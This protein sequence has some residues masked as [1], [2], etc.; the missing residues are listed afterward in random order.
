M[1]KKCAIVGTAESYSMTPW[2]DT[3]IKIVALNDSYVLG[4]PRIDEF[5]ELHPLDKMYFRPRDQRRVLETAV[6]PGHYV[7][8]EGH[9][10]FLKEAAKTIPVWLQH[11]PPTD[12]PEKAC[13]FPIEAI[14]AKYGTYWASGPAYELMHLYER[15][16]REIHIYG[17]HLATD[18]ERQDQRHNFEFLI[19]RLLGPEM[20]ESRQGDLR[21]FEGRETKIVLP[22]ASPLLQHGW[23]Y[24]YESKPV[25]PKTE[26]D[27]EWKD[28]QKEKAELIRQLVH[29]RDEAYR[30]K[31]LAR[32]S[33]VEVI[34]TDIQQ[35]MQRKHLGAPLAITIQPQ[36]VPVTMPVPMQV[37]DG[38]G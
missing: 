26:L 6:P 29:C 7:R 12:W 33:R 1:T 28:I 14:E 13:R 31:A 10:E 9:I 8:P 19:G 11:T 15:G 34:E 2:H 21:V 23:K 18:H 22:V 17:I 35:Q 38:H 24:A 32:L 3:S 37:G 5:Y 36:L 27:L 4:L 16:F 25:K 20:R 30:V